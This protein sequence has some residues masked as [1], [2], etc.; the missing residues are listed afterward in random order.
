MATWKRLSLE[1]RS[2]S[3]HG[4]HKTQGHP[5]SAETLAEG[6]A[7]MR[8]SGHGQSHDPQEQR[9]NDG[10]RH[11]IEGAENLEHQF[12]SLRAS[13]TGSPGIPPLSEEGVENLFAGIRGQ[14]NFRSGREFRVHGVSPFLH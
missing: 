5:Q 6:Y 10:Q 2:Q 12:R 3:A 7:F 9:G 13:K 14:K 8:R 4:P 1:D 11:Q